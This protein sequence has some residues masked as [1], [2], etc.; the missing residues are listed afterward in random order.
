MPVKFLKLVSSKYTFGHTS[1]IANTNTWLNNIDLSDSEL[2]TLRAGFRPGGTM[3]ES[4]TIQTLYHEATHAYLDLRDDEKKFKDFIKDGDNYYK[5]A[6]LE[7]GKVAKDPDRIF[8]E[9]A[10]SYVGDRAASWYSSYDFIEVLR[11]SVDK[12]TW[13]G[14]GNKKVYDGAEKLARKV[15]GEY[16]RS[17]RDR[18]FGYEERWGDQVPTTKPIS[19]AIK[20]FCDQEILEGK[21]PD[22]FDSSAFLKD[23]LQSLLDLIQQSRTIVP[24]EVR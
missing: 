23:K 14:E 15:P 8:Q 21:I 20:V 6:P 3:G 4:T 17:M 11:E 19:A 22:G 12:K 18:V 13:D 1:G 9:A 10:A 7:G 2:S 5:D 16:D 24:V